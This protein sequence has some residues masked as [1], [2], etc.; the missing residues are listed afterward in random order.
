MSGWPKCGW[1]SNDTG[2]TSGA[3][4]PVH[5]PLNESCFTCTKAAPQSAAPHVGLH[6]VQW[7]RFGT[8][9]GMGRNGSHG[10]GSYNCQ[11]SPLCNK[12]S[13]WS[14][15]LLFPSFEKLREENGEMTACKVCIMSIPKWKVWF[16]GT[17]NFQY[18][19]PGEIWCSELQQAVRPA[20]GWSFNHVWAISNIC[21]ICSTDV[22][23]CPYMIKWPPFSLVGYQQLAYSGSVPIFWL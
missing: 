6:K 23:D 18:V 1:D 14:R 4:P 12:N 9:H 22:W 13:L 20:W 2:Y 8:H 17:W 19:W 16:I 11:I 10:L 7:S 15:A 3:G 21:T 5:F